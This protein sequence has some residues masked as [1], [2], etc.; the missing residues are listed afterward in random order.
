MAGHILAEAYI[1]L[2]RL[3]NNVLLEMY[4]EKN[5]TLDCG[6]EYSFIKVS[7]NQFYGIEIKA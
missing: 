1:S 6:E 7:I 2:R 5:L 3:E 4:K